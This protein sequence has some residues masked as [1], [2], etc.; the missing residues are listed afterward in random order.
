MHDNRGA[1]NFFVECG[2]ELIRRGLDLR[3][4]DFGSFERNASRHRERRI[5][6]VARDLREELE[7]DASGC[8]HGRC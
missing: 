1:R 7:A 6:N 2:D 8:D 5:G 3:D 4:G